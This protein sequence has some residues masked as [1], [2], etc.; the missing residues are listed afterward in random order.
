MDFIVF[1]I[2]IGINRS[3]MIDQVT[4]IAGLDV[5]TQANIIA[6]IM[7]PYAPKTLQGGG[8]FHL[9]FGALLTGATLKDKLGRG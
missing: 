2:Y 1:P 6:S 4:S 9:A 5:T 3:D 8:M 7:K